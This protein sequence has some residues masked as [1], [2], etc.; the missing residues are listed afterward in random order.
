MKAYGIINWRDRI[1]GDFSSGFIVAQSV[2]RKIQMPPTNRAKA[3]VRKN[4]CTIGDP[5]HYVGVGLH[6]GKRRLMILK[7]SAP[8]T[9]IH[10]LRTDTQAD[11]GLIAAYWQ[12]IIDSNGR[13][14]IANEFDVRV[15][16]VEGLL[17]VLRNF[18][19]DNL[20]IEINSAEVP[21]LDGGG[22]SLVKQIQRTGIVPQPAPRCGIWIEKPI[23]CRL[24]GG[25]A[26]LDPDSIPR[27]TISVGFLNAHSGPHHA[28]LEIIDPLL[29]RGPEMDAG[30]SF[31]YIRDYGPMLGGARYQDITVEDN[32]NSCPAGLRYGET[33]VRQKALDCLGN[34]AL[35]G[36]PIFGH[37]HAQNPGHR[38]I[39]GLLQT[40]FDHQDSWSYLRY[41][42]IQ[43]RVES[44]Q[45]GTKGSLGSS[46]SN[47]D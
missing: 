32:G 5:V 33:L 37:L 24:G 39:H 46:P 12:N 11:H 1:S 16:G 25:I 10:F 47:N 42:E 38:L 17:A 19:I 20:L 45:K 26:T 9:G 8:Y 14:V 43:Q 28:S 13:T 21:V 3:S 30:N 15:G 6:S 44:R 22:E 18:G 27:I 29:T 34:L 31:D 23:E 2:N 4:Q 35:A 41:A 36:A 7:P 40:L